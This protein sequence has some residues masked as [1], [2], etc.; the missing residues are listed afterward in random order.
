VAGQKLFI[1]DAGFAIGGTD[2]V[3]V[4]TF[5]GVTGQSASRPKGLIVWMSKDSQES[6]FCIGAKHTILDL[7]ESKNIRHKY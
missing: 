4:H 6:S 5:V 7:S 1:Y 2:E 3:N